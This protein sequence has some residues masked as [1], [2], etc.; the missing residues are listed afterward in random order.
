MSVRRTQWERRK[1]S[2]GKLD[3][4][5]RRRAGDRHIET[6]V[7][8]TDADDRHAEI[9]GEIKKGI[10]TA[11]SKSITVD[12]AGRL[13]LESCEAGG[14]ERATIDAPAAHQPS[15]RAPSWP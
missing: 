2:R 12:E 15:H 14:Q 4:R 1:A 5:L 11:T 6:F 8:K 7:R 10:D 3:R 13:W 9:K